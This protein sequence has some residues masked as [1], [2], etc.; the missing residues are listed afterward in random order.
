MNGEITAEELENE[1]NPYSG[2][3]PK[4]IELCKK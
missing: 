3:D 4:T 1:G 2:K